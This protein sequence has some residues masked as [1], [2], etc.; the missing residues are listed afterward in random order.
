MSIQS[1]IIRIQGNVADAY[2]A[3]LGKG[4]SMPSENNTANL[5]R[6]IESIASAEAMTVAQ[7]R[8]ICT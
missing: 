1:E 6:T 3:L 4:A 8:A 5:A 2:S 7:I